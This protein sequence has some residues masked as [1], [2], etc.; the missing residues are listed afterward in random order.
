MPAGE[1]CVSTRAAARMRRGT[2]L[3]TRP[4]PM[5]WRTER[6]TDNEFI[7]NRTFDEIRL[8]DTASM[9]RAVSEKDIQLFA[10][11]S[12]D[13]S[14]DHRDADFAQTD[15][16]Q[17][18]SAH[19]SWGG[20]L[21]SAVLGTELPGPGTIYLGQSLRFERPVGIGDVITASV[22]VTEKKAQNQGIVL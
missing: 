11:A 4:T 1:P 13:V 3:A 14:P 19:G 8:G 9:S 5:F 7:E 6:V 12:G 18:I 21:I 10:L 16:F 15:G 20:G 17:R 22:T 2:V